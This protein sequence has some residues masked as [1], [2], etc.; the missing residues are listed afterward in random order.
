MI[1]QQERDAL[2]AEVER[3]KAKLGGPD[4]LLKLD[5]YED[6]IRELMH[7]LAVRERQAEILAGEGWSNGK[8]SDPFKSE[9][10]SNALS[11][12]RAEIAK[13]TEAKPGTQITRHEA[14]DISRSILLNTEQAR[15]E[16]AETEAKQGIQYD[17]LKPEGKP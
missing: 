17:E 10:L 13:E 15:D 3:L 8:T 4:Y 14:L 2:R 12:A 5:T 6:T 1:P 11:Q 16:Q 9:R 7:E